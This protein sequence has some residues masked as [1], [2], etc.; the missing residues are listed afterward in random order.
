VCLFV[1]P[2][3]CMFVFATVFFAFNGKRK[4]SSKNMN[5]LLLLLCFLCE[6]LYPIAKAKTNIPVREAYFDAFCEANHAVGRTNK[7]TRTS[8]W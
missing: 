7:R 2:A 8:M 6:G 1:Q 5:L 3:G 4:H